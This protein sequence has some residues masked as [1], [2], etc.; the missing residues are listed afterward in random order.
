MFVMFDYLVINLYTGNDCFNDATAFTINAAAVNALSIL[1][2]KW[3]KLKNRL[4]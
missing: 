3:I 4:L 2:R 1:L